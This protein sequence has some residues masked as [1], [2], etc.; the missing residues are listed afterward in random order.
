MYTLT[1]ACEVVD[2]LISR[3]FFSAG[4][5]GTAHTRASKT[6]TGQLCHPPRGPRPLHREPLFR[7]AKFGIA[8]Y[9]MMTVSLFPIFSAILLDMDNKFLHL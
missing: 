9:S 3:I 7:I 4:R 5:S 2:H 8:E 1:M 6:R